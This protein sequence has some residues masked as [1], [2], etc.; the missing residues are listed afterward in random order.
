MVGWWRVASRS[1]AGSNA[2]RRRGCGGHRVVE[3]SGDC[4]DAPS[5]S[6]AAPATQPSR[7]EAAKVATAPAGHP[8]SAPVPQAPASASATSAA[9][10]VTAIHAALDSA[11]SAVQQRNLKHA[12]SIYEEV[13]E[14]HAHRLG[15]QTSGPR[16]TPTCQHRT[17]S[18]CVSTPT[19]S[20]R[21]SHS[22]PLASLS[23]HSAA[24]AVELTLEPSRSRA[25]AGGL[26]GWW[27]WHRCCGCVQTSHSAC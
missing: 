19:H 1:G 11:T 23:L 13:C 22:L 18:I 2:H 6:A 7:N 16:S 8:P 24:F 20:P 21:M 5:S 25:R 14:P 26:D 10:G 9:A 17:A 15:T 12:C 3:S 27:R 4:V